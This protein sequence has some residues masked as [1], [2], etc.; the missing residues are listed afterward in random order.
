MCINLVHINLLIHSESEVSRSVIS[1]TLRP[2]GLSM[3]FSRPEY[4]S[5]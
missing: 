1:D 3:E 4:W 5:G 2:H